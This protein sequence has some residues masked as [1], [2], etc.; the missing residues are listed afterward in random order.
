MLARWDRC[1]TEPTLYLGT[2][3]SL[4]APEWPRIREVVIDLVFEGG[5]DNA[6]VPFILERAEI[7][8]ER[9]DQLFRDKQDCLWQVYDTNVTELE[10]LVIAAYE[11]HDRWRDGLRAAAYAAARW[12]QAN[13][14]LVSFGPAIWRYPGGKV[15]EARYDRCLQQIVD[16]VD[17][18]RQELDDP[19][20]RTRA[21]AESVLGSVSNSVGKWL[22][23]SSTAD[24]IVPQLM[25]FAV[26]PYLGPEAASEEL[27]I[28]PPEPAPTKATPARSS[29]ILSGDIQ[30]LL[31]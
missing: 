30:K 6:S 10:K 31:A 26:R 22:M 24:D 20:S 18:G 1:R 14:R 9:F 29:A 13:P 25:S 15:V 5:Y 2:P 11:A 19:D 23:D 27:S 16:L 21:T 8:Q 4:P 12:M 28:P 17:A 7:S 3:M